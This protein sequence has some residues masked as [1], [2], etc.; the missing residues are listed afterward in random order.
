MKLLDYSVYKRLYD[1][2]SFLKNADVPN[3][4]IIMY[5]YNLLYIVQGP[6]FHTVRTEVNQSI[7]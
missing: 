3:S 7:L 6:I 1:F 2:N 5:P 4:R